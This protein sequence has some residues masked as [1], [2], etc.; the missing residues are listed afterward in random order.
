[1]AALIDIALGI[2]LR[3]IPALCI[4]SKAALQDHA[5]AA[6]AFAPSIVGKCR[7]SVSSSNRAHPRSDATGAERT[8]TLCLPI[9]GCID[10]RGEVEQYEAEPRL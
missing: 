8:S 1:M 2:W 6:P 3:P 9:E 4:T 5:C 7:S 10:Q